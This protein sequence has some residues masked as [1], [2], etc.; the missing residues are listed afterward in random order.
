MPEVWIQNCAWT[1]LPDGTEV[2]HNLGRPASLQ[3]VLRLAEIPARRVGDWP[4]AQVKR[5]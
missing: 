5:L 1:P 3:E 2:W 4:R